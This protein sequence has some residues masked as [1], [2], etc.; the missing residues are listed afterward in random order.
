MTEILQLIKNLHHTYEQLKE[1][2]GLTP[3]Q[4]AQLLQ[5]KTVPLHHCCNEP[6]QT[7]FFTQHSDTTTHH[8]TTN[9][10]Y[11]SNKCAK[12]QAQRMYRKRKAT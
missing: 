2:Y 11:C 12:A 5:G 8:R 10:L 9:V 1:Q 4:A 6:C 3:N 7:R